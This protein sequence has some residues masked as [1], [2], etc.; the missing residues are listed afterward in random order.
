MSKRENSIMTDAVVRRTDARVHDIAPWLRSCPLPRDFVPSRD[1]DWNALAQHLCRCGLAG[2][3][4]AHGETRGTAFPSWVRDIL[5]DSAS[6][7]A[8]DNLHMMHELECLLGAFN[9]HEIPV[10]LLKGAALN[11]MVYSSAS[12]RPM[13]D[14]DL[15][16]RPADARKALQ[17]LDELGCRRGKRLVRDD[18]FPKFHY[19][20]EVIVP[21]VRPVRI[22]LHARPLRPLR[23]SRTV[24]DE[25]FWAG[26]LEARVGTARA[27]IPRTEFNF[28]HLAAHAAFH[29]CSR[30]IWLHDIRRLFEL[31]GQTLDW[32]LIVARCREWRLSC[33]VREA[34]VRVEATFGRTFPAEVVEELRMDRFSW[35]DRLT[36]W[37]APRDG[38]SPIGHVACNLLCTPGIRFRLGYLAAILFPA[39][40]HLSEVYRW[41]HVGWTIC[42]SVWRAIRALRRL[43]PLPLASASPSL[44]R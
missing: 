38:S 4:L 17:L 20:V 41:R 27:M 1:A 36:L 42:A 33:A 29:G 9:G 37:H 35:R 15:L 11:R 44:A 21:S 24:P 39:R 26:A 18:F 12:Q 7:V 25:S 31:H 23:V 5:H 16:V 6:R 10:M 2:L 13:S 3:V 32:R 40:G 19:E 43:I 8:A 34:I 14:I 22:D 30:L 28:I